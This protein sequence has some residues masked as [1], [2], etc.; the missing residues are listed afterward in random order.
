MLKS[1]NSTDMMKHSS[2]KNTKMVFQSS[3]GDSEMIRGIESPGFMN[4]L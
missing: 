1:G 3:Q 2:D 4:K